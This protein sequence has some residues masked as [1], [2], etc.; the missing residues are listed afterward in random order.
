M[1]IYE[2]QKPVGNYFIQFK[3]L[4]IHI[5]MCSIKAIRRREWQQNSKCSF[6]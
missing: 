5:L 4:M 2:N 3:T 6:T 1:S